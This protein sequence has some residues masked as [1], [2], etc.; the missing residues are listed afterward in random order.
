MAPAFAQS[1]VSWTVPAWCTSKAL[2]VGK[3]GAAEPATQAWHGTGLAP[4]H[5]LADQGKQQI[6]D[7]ERMVN[8]SMFLPSA[9][10]RRYL[11]R[12]GHCLGMRRQHHHHALK[13]EAWCVRQ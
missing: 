5:K 4:E 13:I 11:P 6:N 12:A 1:C 8:G 2:T 9:G 7:M 10:L 3:A